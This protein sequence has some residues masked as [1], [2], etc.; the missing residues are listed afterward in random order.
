MARRR[1]AARQI[2]HELRETE[3]APGR[4]RTVEV[5]CKEL[6]VTGQSYYPCR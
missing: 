1:Y 6:E 3:M 4:S 5:V 2:I